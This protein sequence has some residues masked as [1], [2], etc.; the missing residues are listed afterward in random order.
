VFVKQS[1]LSSGVF[2]TMQV[3]THPDGLVLDPHP[4]ENPGSAK[5]SPPCK[6]RLRIKNI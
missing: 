4:K 1:Y 5:A 6:L 3:S 2:T